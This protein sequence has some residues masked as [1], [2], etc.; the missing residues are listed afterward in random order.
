MYFADVKQ[1]FVLG[2]AR[3]AGQKRA[4]RN[5]FVLREQKKKQKKIACCCS[6]KPRPKCFAVKKILTGVV[7]VTADLN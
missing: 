4:N 3:E 1:P 2:C 6:Q 5:G 7:I